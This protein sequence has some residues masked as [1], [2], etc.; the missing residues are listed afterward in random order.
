MKEFG[1][2]LNHPVV[3]YNV[4]IS[5]KNTVQAGT[6]ALACSQYFVSMCCGYCAYSQYSEVLYCGYFRP[7]SILGLGTVCILSVL[8]VFRGPVYCGYSKS[9]GSISSVG[10]ACTVSTH[11]ISRFCTDSSGLA[12]FWGWVPCAF[13]L[14]FKYFGVLCTAGT[15]KV[16]VVFRPLVLLVLRILTVFRGSVRMTPDSQYFGIRY[17]A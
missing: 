11:S 8:E 14:Y 13:S 17:C 7:R 9:T 12:V 3:S 4:G 2:I 16:L 15:A 6:C 5:E 10:T 1:V